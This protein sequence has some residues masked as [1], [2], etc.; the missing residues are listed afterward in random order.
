M[1]DAAAPDAI[2]AWTRDGFE[3]S[4][5]PA[6]L[7]PA[8][9]HA[10]LSRSY[11]AEEI[12]LAL[13]RKSLAASYCFGLY[14]GAAQVGLARVVTDYATF[15]YLCD[16]Y[17]LETHQG[18][19]LGQWLMQ[20]VMGSARLQGLRRWMLVTRDAHALYAKLGW[21][22][23]AN[24]AGYMEIARPGMYRQPGDHRGDVR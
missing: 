2:E 13:V 17:V 3:V 5:D 19:G 23:P 16:V 1:A 12:P 6:R 7:D 22:P 20:C 14:E 10:Y 24:P 4:T 9:I 21:Q 8:A 11:W 15:A 18:R